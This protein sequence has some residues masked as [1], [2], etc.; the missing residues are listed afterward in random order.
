MDGE[1]AQTEAQEVQ[2]WE[3]CLVAGPVA[4]AFKSN[5]IQN[6]S[7][8]HFVLFYFIIFLLITVWEIH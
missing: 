6:S 1:G 3:L 8:G 5:L 7:W 2:E 4:T